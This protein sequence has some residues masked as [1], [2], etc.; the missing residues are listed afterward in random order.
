ME[1]SRSPVILGDLRTGHLIN[2]YA[3]QTKPAKR[4]RAFRA[5]NDLSDSI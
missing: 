4:C 1:F 2:Q 5:D 3:I